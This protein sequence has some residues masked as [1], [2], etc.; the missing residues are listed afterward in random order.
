MPRKEK[1]SKETKDK[2]SKALSKRI[3]FNCDMCG[4]MS[5]ESPSHYNKKKRHFCSMG[6]YSEFRKTKL[7]LEEQHAYKG[8][9]KEGDSKQTEKQN[10]P[11]RYAAT[12]R[13]WKQNSTE[14]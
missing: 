1:H 6:C 10:Q 2:I 13:F 3:E 8:L 4:K 12:D 5:S 14:K 9:R 11:G 7:P